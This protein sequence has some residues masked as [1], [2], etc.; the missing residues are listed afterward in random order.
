MGYTTDFSGSFQ[1]NRPLTV[2]EKNYIN[3]FSE[4]RR[5]KRDVQKLFKTYKGE[6]GLPMVTTI[7]TEMQEH[8]NFLEGAGYK[9]SITPLKDKRKPE[10]I[11][12]VDGGYFVGGKGHAG[13]VHDASI[14]DYNGT[15]T[16]QPG[17]WCQWTVNEDGT[18]LEW[19]G[20]E[21]FYSY[22]E[23]LQYLINHFFSKWGVILNGEVEWQGEDATDVGKIVVTNNEVKVLKGRVVYE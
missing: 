19:D 23:W 22:T 13:Q 7:T 12:G 20:G 4:T 8:I 11:Y 2:Q 18:R 5:M 3:K 9:V 10:E 14:I 17:L 1:F 6:H 21:K 15:P 16:G